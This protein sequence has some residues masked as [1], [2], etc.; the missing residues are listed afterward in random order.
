[1]LTVAS[2]K[3]QVA[4]KLDQVDKACVSARH[5]D[6]AYLHKNGQFKV[7]H[8]IDVQLP[9]RCHSIRPRNHALTRIYNEL[10]AFTPCL[11]GQCTGTLRWRREGR[12]DGCGNVRAKLASLLPSERADNVHIAHIQQQQQQQQGRGGGTAN[13]DIHMDTPRCRLHACSAFSAAEPCL[14]VQFAPNCRGV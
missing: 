10:T 4:I 13:N 5:V 9:S 12:C 8:S 6:G 1:M 3:V 7:E 11:I 2:I 14:N